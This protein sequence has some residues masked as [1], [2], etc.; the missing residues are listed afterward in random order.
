MFVEKHSTVFAKSNRSK[1]LRNT[2]LFSEI[3][4]ASRMKGPK[5]RQKFSKG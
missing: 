5:W 4:A 3:D 1:L 2:A